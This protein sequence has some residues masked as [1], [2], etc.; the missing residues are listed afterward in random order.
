MALSLG[1]EPFTGIMV[2]GVAILAHA[3]H[4]R[5]VRYLFSVK[6]RHYKT[7]EKNIMLYIITNEQ[8]IMKQNH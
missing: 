2:G 3:V 4:Q 6:G 5:S 7:T 1:R 8:N